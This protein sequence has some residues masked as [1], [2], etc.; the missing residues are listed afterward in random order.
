MRKAGR[1][2]QGVSL[3]RMEEEG[4]VVAVCERGGSRAQGEGER[5]RSWLASG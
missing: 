5:R 3:E 4:G 2:G 1:A